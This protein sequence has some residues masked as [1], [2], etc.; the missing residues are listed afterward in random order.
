MILNPSNVKISDETSS[1]TFIA[2]RQ[3]DVECSTKVK[4]E[5]NCENDGDEA[6]LTIYIS[7]K[8]YYSFAKKREDGKNYIIIEK[9]M[10]NFERVK[11][12]IEEGIIN[13]KIETYKENYKFY[14]SINNG[15]YECMGEFEV[16][17]RENAGKCFTGTL[18]GIY[19]QCSTKTNSQAEIYSFETERL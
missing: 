11:K 1:P 9:H 14:Y 3:F 10:Q 17:A 12:E 19:A 16:F 18:I 2:V 13:F 15:E 5:F 8:G 7:N 6:G 4:M